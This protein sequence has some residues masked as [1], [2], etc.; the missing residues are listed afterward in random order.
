MSIFKLLKTHKSVKAVI[1]INPEDEQKFSFEIEPSKDTKS[2]T[3]KIKILITDTN[4]DTLIEK[5]FDIV[6]EKIPELIEIEIEVD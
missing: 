3:Y 6:I 1:K 2:G 5:S 4:T